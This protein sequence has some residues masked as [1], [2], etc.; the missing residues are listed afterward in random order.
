MPRDSAQNHLIQDESKSEKV[1]NYL[2]EV[3]ESIDDTKKYLCD[4]SA[5]RS[6]WKMWL[7]ARHRPI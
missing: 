4:S 5:P 1:M 6:S 3:I 2:R 7:R